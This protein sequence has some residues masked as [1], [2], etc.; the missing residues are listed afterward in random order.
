MAYTSFDP[1]QQ[2]EIA[3]FREMSDGILDEIT[4]RAWSTFREWRMLSPEERCKPVAA[5]ANVLHQ[6]REEIA[7]L[8]AGEMGKPV[9]QGLAETDKCALLC[10]WY[11]EH[12]P[13]LL[14]PER[15]PSSAQVSYVVHEPQGIILGIMPWNFPFWQVFRFII[16]A[17][18]GGNAALL[19][20]A[21]SVP[22]CALEI[23]DIVKSAG[24]PVGLFR[25]IFPSHQQVER[26]I[27]D[28][29]IRGVS[30][31][32]STAAGK[33][34]ASVAGTNLKKMVMELGGSDPFIVFPD[35]DLDMAV[36]AAVFSRYQNGGQSCIAAKRII[37]HTVVYEEFR[38]KFVSA[39][40]AL[41]SGDPLD[42]LTD[43]GPL[44]NADAAEE[45]DR[46]LRE[47]V[48]A[49][50][51]LL[52]GGRAGTEHPAL[53]IPAVVDD[54][55][56]SSPLAC[57]ET[58]GPA[59]PLMRFRDAGEAVALANSTPFGLGAT[60]WTSD[61]KLAMETAREIDT[62]TVAINGFVKSE[63]GLPFGGTKESGYGRELAA[64]GLRELLNIKT[65]SIFNPRG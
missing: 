41:R 37:V 10:R 64:E 16:P 35:A 18:A 32:G 4:E 45:L 55:P 24:F 22:R 62:G 54:V 58:F 61:E 1:W 47:T 5:M 7:K 11:A 12:A 51:K 3:V 9:T 44:V 48:R 52:C 28:R 26:V 43:V 31:T 33:R 29:R 23:E 2:K 39:V 57:E 6:R 14:E 27:A 21:S 36:E 40:K 49:G 59:A 63:P 25:T 53:F 42:P 38:A 15:R 8:M 20:H 60:V 46:Q 56:L 30:L 34:I 13:G 65:I 50:A 17:L 19:K